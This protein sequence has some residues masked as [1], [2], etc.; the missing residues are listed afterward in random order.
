[1]GRKTK[2]SHADHFFNTQET[3]TASSKK[4]VLG[5]EHVT[6]TTTN[7]CVLS[8]VHY[9]LVGTSTSDVVLE[10]AFAIRVVPVSFVTWERLLPA[11]FRLSYHFFSFRN[12]ILQVFSFHVQKT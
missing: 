11:G 12:I 4:K 6:Q 3:C 10:L 7:V 2:A 9:K 8:G 5:L 1:M